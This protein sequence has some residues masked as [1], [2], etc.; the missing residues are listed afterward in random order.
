MP[1]KVLT[2]KCSGCGR[3]ADLCPS[4]PPALKLVGDPPK[5]VLEHPDA[6]LECGVCK[7]VCPERAI[8]LFPEEMGGHVKTQQR[9]LLMTS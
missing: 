5:A 9:S 8:V 2:D 7:A 6:C 4:V 3:C 1:P